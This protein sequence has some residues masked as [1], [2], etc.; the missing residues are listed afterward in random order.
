MV[1]ERV[2]SDVPLNG[3]FDASML[4]QARQ[5]QAHYAAWSSEI[6]NKV[7]RCFDKLGNHK[8]GNRSRNAVTELVE[9]TALI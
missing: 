4:R 7:F 1:P 2:L 5:P 3:C 6:I 8:L 9:V